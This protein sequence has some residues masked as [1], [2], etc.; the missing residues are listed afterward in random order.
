MILQN[1]RTAAAPDHAICQ[2]SE[3]MNVFIF[4]SSLR[5]KKRI[6]DHQVEDQAGSQPQLLEF[7]QLH[8]Q[9]LQPQAQDQL[10]QGH[11]II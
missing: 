11:H 2:Y 1:A 7:Q 10:G 8:Q 9:S 3:S 5:K 6:Q 4:F